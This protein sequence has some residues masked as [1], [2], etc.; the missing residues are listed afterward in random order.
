MV[1]SHLE[2]FTIEEVWSGVYFQQHRFYFIMLQ[3]YYR[4]LCL[5]VI[6]MLFS[7]YRFLLDTL[8]MKVTLR[9]LRI[10]NIEKKVQLQ[11][12]LLLQHHGQLHGFRIE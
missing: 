8:I 4:Q 10:N 6:F 9:K 5:S 7:D 12:C 11:I 3:K 1:M 2:Y